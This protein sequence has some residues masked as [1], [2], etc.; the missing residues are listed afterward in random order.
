MDALA[1]VRTLL[2]RVRECVNEYG[3]EKYES[4]FCTT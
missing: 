2:L 1:L 4:L 3:E